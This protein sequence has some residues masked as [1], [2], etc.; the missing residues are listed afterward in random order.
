MLDEEKAIAILARFTDAIHELTKRTLVQC[1][2][3]GLSPNEGVAIASAGLINESL[4]MEFAVV[5]NKDFDNAT[6]LARVQKH[7]DVIHAALAKK[8][9]ESAEEE[10]KPTIQ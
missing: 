2:I 3:A 5:L 10:T 4:L 1:K 6:Y 7:I 9:I 8:A